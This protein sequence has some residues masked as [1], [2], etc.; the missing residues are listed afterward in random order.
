MQTNLFPALKY[1]TVAAVLLFMN[2]CLPDQNDDPSSSNPDPKTSE[3]GAGNAATADFGKTKAGEPT[4]IYTLKNKNGL[5]A[6][7]LLKA[8]SAALKRFWPLRMFPIFIHD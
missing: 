5:I 6:K 4:E 2:A 1:S 7:V 8:I 3:L